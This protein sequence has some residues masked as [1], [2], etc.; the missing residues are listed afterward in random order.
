MLE[1]LKIYIMDLV[2]VFVLLLE[3]SFAQAH[4]KIIDELF[5]GEN[6]LLETENETE[7]KHEHEN[8]I[9]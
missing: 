9:E 6:A 8:I 4:F 7:N 2:D 1:N 3:T 5:W